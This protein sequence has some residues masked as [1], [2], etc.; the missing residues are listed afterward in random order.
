MAKSMKPGSGKTP[1]T[2]KANLAAEPA[3]VTTGKVASV[4]PEGVSKVVQ[5]GTDDKAQLHMR[6]APFKVEIVDIDVVL[7]FQDGT[8]IVIPGMA[9]AVFSGRKAQFVFDDKEV[10]AESSFAQVGEIKEQP[11]PMKLA[12]S[13]AASDKQADA[14]GQGE[15]PQDGGAIQPKDSQAQQAQA[16]AK[17]ESQHKSDGEAQRLTQKISNTE[18]SASAPSNPPSARS[19]APAP[20]DAIAPAGIGNAAEVSA[21]EIRYQPGKRDRARLVLRYVGG[22]G[23]LIEDRALVDADL[24]AQGAALVD[25]GAESS[26]AHAGVFAVIAS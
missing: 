17:E 20:D 23:R 10:D 6:Y 25:V 8:K 3:E 9:L 1:Q 4:L 16:A 11:L 24:A 7:V 22:V 2:P 21:T 14:H 12:L 19:V 15:K 5:L 26:L 18:S 13:S